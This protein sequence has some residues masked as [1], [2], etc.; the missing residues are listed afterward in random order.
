MIEPANKSVDL[1]ALRI[2]RETPPDRGRWVFPAIATLIVGVVAVVLIRARGSGSLALRPLEVATTRAAL[3]TP[4]QAS[5]VLTA[6]GYIVARAKAEI[7]PKSVGRISWLN[8]EEGQKV[9]K[10]E[11]VARLESQELAAQKQQAVAQ[12]QQYLAQLENATGVVDRRFDLA[13]VAHDAGVAEQAGD[14]AGAEAGDLGGIEAGEGAAEGFALVED[15]QPAQARLETLEAQLLEQAPVVDH[16]K[17]PLAVVVVPV[18]RAGRAP[19]AARPAVFGG[20]QAPC[21]GHGSLSAR[22]QR[23]ASL[24]PRLLVSSA[25]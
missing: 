16:G 15:R 12:R 10:G 8:L 14:V 22:R 11:L 20:E 6:S 13:A 17:A 24:F 25:P 18:G 23:R 7:S 1:S 9:K 19:E 4:V 5:T 2:D 21:G 3:V